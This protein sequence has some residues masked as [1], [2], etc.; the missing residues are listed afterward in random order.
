LEF[1]S[2]SFSLSRLMVGKCYREK[3]EETFRQTFPFIHDIFSFVLI[4]W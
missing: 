2:L 4:Y 3:R 1:F